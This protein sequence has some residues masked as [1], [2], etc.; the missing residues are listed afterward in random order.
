MNQIRLCRKLC[1]GASCQ[2]ERSVLASIENIGKD[3]RRTSKALQQKHRERTY[4]LGDQVYLLRMHVKPGI[5]KKLVKPWIGSYKIIEV[6]GPVTYRVKKVSE[7]D[8]QVVHVNWLKSY[9]TYTVEGDDS[10]E[11]NNSDDEEEMTNSSGRTS[12]N[13]R[14]EEENE[15]RIP[16]LP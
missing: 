7:T 9:S 3:Q 5:S 14:K 11:S 13:G 6:I 1:F 2:T 10:E 16:I 8:E 12:R 15:K 4:E